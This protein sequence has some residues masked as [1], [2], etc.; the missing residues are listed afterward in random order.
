[1]KSVFF[2]SY[3][4]LFLLDLMCMLVFFK[5]LLRKQVLEVRPNLQENL[6]LAKKT[7]GT[8]V[9]GRYITANTREHK[10]LNLWSALCSVVVHGATPIAREEGL[11]QTLIKLK[12][13]T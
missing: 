5:D 6:K 12:S 11:N 3:L 9:L 8:V 7:G 1:M 2:A 13:L 4:K 10:N